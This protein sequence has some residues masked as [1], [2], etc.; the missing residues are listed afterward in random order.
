M[1]LIKYSVG[2]DKKQF[3]MPAWPTLWPGIVDGK[4]NERLDTRVNPYIS[5]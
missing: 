3:F 2:S 4:S 1:N 5:S